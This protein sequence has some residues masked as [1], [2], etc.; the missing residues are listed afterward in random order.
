MIQ[1]TYMPRPAWL[2]AGTVALLLLFWWSYRRAK[3]RPSTSLK[4]AL[5]ALRLLAIAAIVLCLMD[6]QWVEMI[7]HDQK[8]R[9]AVLLDNSRSMSIGDLPGGRLMAAKQWINKQ[10]L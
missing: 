9:V 3:G 7:K 6:P 10:M 8:S 1:F 2:I 5:M 4:V